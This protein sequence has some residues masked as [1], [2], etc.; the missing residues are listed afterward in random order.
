[1]KIK[2]QYSFNRPGGA[3]CAA[4]VPLALL[5]LCALHSPL[6]TAE[7][8]STAFTYE[9]QLNSSNSPA[10]G[11]YDFTFAL[12]N[13]SSTNTGQ[14]GSTLTNLD[15][16][17]TNGLFSVTLDF[18]AVFTGNATWLAMGVRT[19]GGANFTGLRPS[20][21]LTPMPY[22]IMANTAS[23]LLG[24]LPAAQLSGTLPSS[25]L[26]GYSGTV[27]LTNG[28]NSF[29]GSF[30]SSFGGI[31]GL[32]NKRLHR[33]HQRQ[34]HKQHHHHDA[35]G[36]FVFPAVSVEYFKAFDY[37]SHSSS[38]QRVGA[39]SLRV[40]LSSSLA[41]ILP[42]AS[43]HPS[44]AGFRLRMTRQP[45]CASTSTSFCKWQTSSSGCGTGMAGESARWIILDFT[46]AV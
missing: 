42:K 41:A 38:S 27:T 25:V 14:V 46:P 39:A 32:G 33:H 36:Q 1:M 7:A 18:G 13:N 37:H 43:S 12:F 34:R 23:N 3:S 5:A 11:N 8:Q 2:I 4:W 40:S 16:G 29:N 21:E 19:N 24:T 31:G 15:V 6:S 17:V 28:S 45:P 20:Q 35:R 44:R 30:S 26:A 9:G 22:A 10:N